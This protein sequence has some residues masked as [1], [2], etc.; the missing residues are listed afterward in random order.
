MELGDY[1]SYKSKPK[2][3]TDAEVK[4]AV[5]RGLELSE[6][7]AANTFTVKIRT[8]AGVKTRK[9]YSSS[10]EDFDILYSAMQKSVYADEKLNMPIEVDEHRMSLKQISGSQ[11]RLVIDE[12]KMED[13]KLVAK[14]AAEE[15]RA[16]TGRCSGGT[17]M[18]SLSN[19]NEDY[20]IIYYYP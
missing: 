14:T 4:E 10:E 7:E 11:N 6:T 8:A 9:I 1:L 17:R 12:L 3:I 19:N 2:E 15:L 5:A 13:K 18:Q 20:F 16:M